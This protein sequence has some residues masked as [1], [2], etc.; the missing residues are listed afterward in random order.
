MNFPLFFPCVTLR[1]CFPRLLALPAAALLLLGGAR[2]AEVENPPE[3]AGFFGQVTGIVRSV[4]PD[5]PSFVMAVTMAK[6]EP[7]AVMSTLKDGAPLVGKELTF[8]VRMP[9][10]PDGVSHPHVD[11]TAYVKSLKVG[12]VI[13][14]KVFA[15]RSS[16]RV[17]RIREPG[18]SAGAISYTFKSINGDLHQPES[19]EFQINTTTMGKGSKF[20]KLGE[21]IPNT[22]FKLDKFQA[23][24]GRAPGGAEIDVSELTLVSIDKGISI[25]LILNK[26]TEVPEAPAAPHK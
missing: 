6:V 5:A 23:K 16:P 17:L 12:M 2:A 19:L 22:K 8:G 15:P 24:M 3:V 18:Q 11:D 7:D 20:L 26:P 1:R 21:V 10:T 9:K 13:T 14:V 4:Q 25:V